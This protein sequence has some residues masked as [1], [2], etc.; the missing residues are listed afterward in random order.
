M[1][2]E[3]CCRDSTAGMSGMKVERYAA[4]ALSEDAGQGEEQAGDD[5]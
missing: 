1:I 2:Y 3:L 5:S 4:A